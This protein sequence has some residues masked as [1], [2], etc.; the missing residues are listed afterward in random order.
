M[1]PKE[2]TVL[3]KDRQLRNTDVP[4]WIEGTL[5]RECTLVIERLRKYEDKIVERYGHLSTIAEKLSVYHTIW[6]N[7]DGLEPCPFD[8]MRTLRQY[9]DSNIPEEIKRK[10]RADKERRRRQHEN[11]RS[12]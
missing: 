9:Y 5:R 1:S 12:G 2:M 10:I 7:W 3:H 4:Q 8:R 6:E 11:S